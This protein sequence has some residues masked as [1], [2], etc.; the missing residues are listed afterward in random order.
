MSEKSWFFAMNDDDLKEGGLEFSRVKGTPV[1]MTRKNGT[2][3]SL[4]GKCKHMGCR[5]SKGTFSDDFILKCACH[6]WEYDIRSGKYLGDKEES[7]ELYEN[8]VEDG[9]IFVLL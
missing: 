9:K 1:L 7:L 2:V 4:F 5:L 8:K 6:G 3:Y